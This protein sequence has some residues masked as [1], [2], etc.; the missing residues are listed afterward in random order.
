MRV[1]LIAGLLVLGAVAGRDALAQAGRFDSG[2]RASLNDK[3]RRWLRRHRVIRVGSDRAWPSPGPTES[4]LC[5]S[6]P[7]GVGRSGR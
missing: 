7:P 2:F 3:E 5:T 4:L 1:L 6:P